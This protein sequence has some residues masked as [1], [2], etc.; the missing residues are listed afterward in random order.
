MSAEY[1]P[2]D[3]GVT[4]SIKWHSCHL[5][6][7]K[8]NTGIQLK[9]TF[10]LWYLYTGGYCCHCIPGIWGWFWSSSSQ[11]DQDLPW[12]SCM[13]L[14]WG[15]LL[16]RMSWIMSQVS[17]RKQRRKASSLPRMQLVWNPSFR[18]HRCV[19]SKA[20]DLHL[21]FV[22]YQTADCRAENTFSFVALKVHWIESVLPLCVQWNMTCKRL[23]SYVWGQFFMIRGALFDRQ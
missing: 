12:V 2:A 13:L 15:C 7:L 23:L 1:W 19:C 6:P 17:W 11:W 8:L 10:S 22:P 20:W 4:C 3:T 9:F 21:S 16:C 18:I 5:T 14:P